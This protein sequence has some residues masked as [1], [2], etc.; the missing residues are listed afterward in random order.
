MHYKP[1]KTNILA[2]ALSHR[3]DYDLRSALSRQEVDNDEDENR[4]AM[5]DVGIAIPDSGLPRVVLY[6]EVVAANV[7][8]T[9]L[10]CVL[11]ATLHRDLYRG[12]SAITSSDI[13]WTETCSN[14]A[15]INSTPLVL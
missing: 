1:G 13:L 10:I 14:T 4:C 6:E 12:Q 15:S 9:L 3:P 8:D 2:D 7:G 5:G 11:P